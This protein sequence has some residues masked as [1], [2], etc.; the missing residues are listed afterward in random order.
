LKRPGRKNTRNYR[1]H[2]VVKRSKLQASIDYDLSFFGDAVL[3][4]NG[5]HDTR[6]LIVEVLAA[7][8]ARIRKWALDSIIFIG[9]S[10]QIGEYLPIS[11]ARFRYKEDKKGFLN[12][13]FVIFS[14][15]LMRLS[16]KEARFTVAHEIAHVRLNQECGGA[17]NE[18]AAD[19]QAAQWGFAPS[20]RRI[21][22]IKRQLI[23][24][25]THHR[26]FRPAR[27]T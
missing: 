6:R 19:N 13:R 25:E 26:R 24:E 10:G 27:F 11:L 15:Q 8:P 22:Q 21:S 2:D 20:Q 17:T 18:R 9:L 4:K 7:L 1:P 3:P 12:V 23:Q 5:E 16:L 14:D